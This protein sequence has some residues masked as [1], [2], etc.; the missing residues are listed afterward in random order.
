MW[1]VTPYPPRCISPAESL[2]GLVWCSCIALPPEECKQTARPGAGSRDNVDVSLRSHGCCCTS[3]GKVP[4][5]HRRCWAASVA[6]S[7]SAWQLSTPWAKRTSPLVADLG[8]FNA[9]GQPGDDVLPSSVRVRA[10]CDGGK[11]SCNSV[12]SSMLTI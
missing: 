1:F 9:E 11:L 2:Q 8:C 5:G 4:A 12:S 10:A 6:W 7:P 3:M